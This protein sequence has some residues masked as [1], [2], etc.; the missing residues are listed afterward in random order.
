[1]LRAG[2]WQESYEALTSA[3]RIENFR[4]PEASYNLG[5]LYATRGEN[6]LAV[7][8]W[9]RVLTLNPK[10][11]ATREALARLGKEGTVEVAV[12]SKKLPP[13]PKPTR[14]SSITPPRSEDPKPV[15]TVKASDKPVSVTAPKTRPMVLTVDQETYDFLLRARNSSERGKVPDAISNYKKAISSNGGYLPPA[16]LE[17]SYLLITQKQYDEALKNLLLVANRDGAQFP[18]SYFHLARL[19]EAS[20]DFKQAEAAFGQAANAFQPTNNQFLLD[21]S[22]V[23]EK[24]GN[25]QGAL[26]ALEQYIERM[27]QQG[28]TVTWSDERISALRQK[29]TPPK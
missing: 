18:I 3:L 26:E 25:Y 27:K 8:E 9:Q 11:T 24:Q 6:D 29:M 17:L 10:H 21:L 12:S 28:H 15:S 16:N 7:R 4:Y 19:Y 22:R 2:R 1:L 5:R 20:G 14:T 23:R 13:P